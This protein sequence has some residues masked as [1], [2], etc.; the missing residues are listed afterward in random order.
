MNR[1]VL[2]AAL[3]IPTAAF[4][5]QPPEKP[6]QKTL[7]NGLRV[8]AKEARG[9]GLVALA[10]MVDGGNRTEPAELSGL[11]HYYEHL[12]FRG[13]T[14]RQAEL[15]T[16]KVF[17]QLGTFYGYTTEDST[18]FY[19]IVPLSNL[20]EA[21][22]RHR[23]AVT[24]VKVT[25]EKVDRE[26]DVVMNEYRMSVADSPSGVL[27]HGLYGKAFEK[28]PYGR[29]TIGLREVI[30][31]SNLDR[32]KSFYEDRY[33]ANQM[34][35]SVVGDLPAQELVRKVEE[36]WKD[37][38]KGK[39]SFELGVQEPKQSEPRTVIQERE[40][41]QQS[42][43]ALA[44]HATEAQ[45]PRR[46]VHDVLS[47]VLSGGDASR[48]QRGLVARRIAL[49]AGAWSPGCKDPGLFAVSLDAE[50]EKEASALEETVS[51]LRSFART[52]PTEEELANAKRRLENETVFGSESLKDE[53]LRL[54]SRAILGDPDVGTTYV[55]KVRAVSAEAVKKAAAEL[56]RSANATLSVMRPRKVDRDWTAILRGLDSGEAR[57]ALVEHASGA[58]IIIE[59]SRR[60]RVVALDMKIAG[61][62]LAE[63]PGEAGV[64]QLTERLLSRGTKRLDRAALARELDRLAVR[65]N[66]AS[67]S[68]ATTLSIRATDETFE[69]AIALLGEML[70][71]PAFDEDEVRRAREETL[72][73][74]ASIE[75]DSF[76]LTQQS[77]A[78]TLYGADHPYG[79]PVLGRKASVSPLSRANL[80]RFHERVYHPENMVVAVVGAIDPARAEQLIEKHLLGQTSGTG[81]GTPR[82]FQV[83]PPPDARARTIL[84]DRKREQATL[85]LGLPLVAVGDKDYLPIQL[86]LRHIGNALFFKYVYEE[87]VAYRMWVYLRQGTGVRPL[88][89]ETGIAPKNFVRVKD[90]LVA[91]V[92]S[93]VEHGLTSEDVA[94]ARKDYV[95]RIL[96]ARETNEDRARSLSSNELQGIGFDFEDR[97]PGLLEGLTAETVNDALK[98]RIDPAKLS[99][100]IVGDRAAL[101]K[102]GASFPA[103]VPREPD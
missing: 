99:L 67:G 43:L 97:L 75:D 80:V 96:L 83:P 65:I 74:I 9:T 6:L 21:L 94:K 16:R 70:H 90:G 2:A 29:K 3:A 15:E 49:S 57:A 31:G 10:C 41:M 58:R 101:E 23:D 35:I 88:V 18:C 34:V 62:Q 22:W 100:V 47:V 7:E 60:S 56:F 89:L 77:F 27:W 82:R 19:F 33:V 98:R 39:A 36:T 51:I 5:D 68:E 92:T 66:T 48:L 20:D 8:V 53:V 38:R 72:E 45:D 4:A 84:L 87:G 11:S 37:A 40:G 63:P 76:G 17:T 71:T 86:A 42:Y 59:E 24:N 30:E 50:P 91:A 93:L 81:T 12:V 54:G 14:A 78:D 32:F 85:D 64:A 73:A 95:N 103:P 1:L 61:G 46:V 102:E 69:P 13:G 55:D 28:H 26:R 52:G 25:Q 79:R 44:F